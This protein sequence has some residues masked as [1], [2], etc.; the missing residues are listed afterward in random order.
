MRWM[1]NS[2]SFAHAPVAASGTHLPPTDTLKPGARRLME[3]AVLAFAERGYHGVSVRDLTSA[4]GINV[5]SFYNH[6]GT[7]E[8]L[9]YELMRFGHEVH[10]TWVRD[11]ILG[12]GADPADQLREGVRANVAFQATYPMITMVC[13]AEQHAL[14]DGH[15]ARIMS[16]RH[17]SGV[18]LEAVM[19]RGNASG[20][21]D[22]PDAWLAISAIAA[23][24]IRV[25]WWFRPE[26]MRTKEPIHRGPSQAASWL[27]DEDYTVEAIADA[28]AD[29]ALRIVNAK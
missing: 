7:K 26:W 24:G 19:E 25:A 29:Y 11:A 17:D 5:A 28:Y 15:H 20:A 2:R 21:F 6:F 22:C 4:V 14:T 9:L 27:P 8:E 16:T 1:T 12:A 10:Q 18:L 13:N 23:M 3:S